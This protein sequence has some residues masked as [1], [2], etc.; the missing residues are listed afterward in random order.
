[1]EFDI[2]EIFNGHATEEIKIC[3][4]ILL[5]QFQFNS[6]MWKGP[7]SPNEMDMQFLTMNF[8]I[9][10]ATL[11]TVNF[12]TFNSARDQ[13]KTLAGLKAQ[14]FTVCGYCNDVKILKS[15]HE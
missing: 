8:I 2:F 10:Q 5:G 15:L 11:Q 13:A 3:P 9:F 7:K 6:L 4:L 14:K 12:S 1:M